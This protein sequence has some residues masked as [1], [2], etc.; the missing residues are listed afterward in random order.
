MLTCQ[1]VILYYQGEHFF[2]DALQLWEKNRFLLKKVILSFPV[3]SEEADSCLSLAVLVSDAPRIK[4]H[5]DFSVVSRLLSPHAPIS[6][7]IR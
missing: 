4:G 1:P 2:L 6:C 3:R 5:I 7:F